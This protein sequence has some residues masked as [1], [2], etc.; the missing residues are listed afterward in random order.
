V[1]IQD[2]IEEDIAARALLGAAAAN[3]ISICP[4]LRC[5]L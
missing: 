3:R 2:A 5:W 1:N 4:R